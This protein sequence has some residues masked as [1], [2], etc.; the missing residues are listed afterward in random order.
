MLYTVS[1]V[2]WERALS[3]TRD[4]ADWYWHREKDEKS[5]VGGSSDLIQVLQK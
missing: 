5:V 3:L 2:E 1:W 4:T